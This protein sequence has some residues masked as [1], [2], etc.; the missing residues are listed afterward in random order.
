MEEKEANVALP[1]EDGSLQDAGGQPE[2]ENGS[3]QEGTKK[4]FVNPEDIE[5]EKRQYISLMNERERQKLLE[6]IAKEE[7]EERLEQERQ[8]RL[9]E[10]K[11]KN[12]V[13]LR[14]QDSLASRI[15]AP[16]PPK[17]PKPAKE[18]KQPKGPKVP[19][20]PKEPGFLKR[21]REHGIY[22]A[23]GMRVRLPV[24]E[25]LPVEAAPAFTAPAENPTPAEVPAAEV[26]EAAA[27]APASLKEA[28]AQV[29][30]DKYAFFYIEPANEEY[31]LANG[32]MQAVRECRT[33]LERCGKR[34]WPGNFYA[35]EETGAYCALMPDCRLNANALKKLADSF[36]FAVQE[37]S[38]NGKYCAA[39]GY[40]SGK[41]GAAMELVMREAIREC[42]RERKAFQEAHP[43][44]AVKAEGIDLEKLMGSITESIRENAIEQA[45]RQYE[46]QLGDEGEIDPEKEIFIRKADEM[47]PEEYDSYLNDRQRGIKEDAKAKYIDDDQMVRQVLHNIGKRNMPD[48]PLYLIAL[49]SPDMNT[50]VLLEDLEDFEAL[51]EESGVELIS[52]SYIYAISRSG[53][54]WYGSSNATREIQ[55]IFNA[56]ASAIADNNGRFQKELLYSVPDIGIFKDIYFY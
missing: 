52:C 7:E 23:E 45:R 33:I 14:L 12:S 20:M 1:E 8:A 13:L 27:A 34:I 21:L 53:G 38:V 51:C 11:R 36:L 43:E 15:A 26:R 55:T 9:R 35:Y 3:G 2:A 39:C 48:D 50:L 18:P 4:R 10:E 6:Q 17:E 49:A 44:F 5:K 37:F 19:E 42:K 22:G 41:P 32:D 54:H 56:L 30:N 29:K 40:A 47:D 46:Q 31:F 24:E 25:A 16:K 28:C